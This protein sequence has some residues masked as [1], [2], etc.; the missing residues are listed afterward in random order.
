MADTIRL[1]YPERRA[2]SAEKILGWA[3]DYCADHALDPADY[4]T[5]PWAIA[6]LEDAGKITTEA[7]RIR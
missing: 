3:R 6:L 7:V 1:L 5:L 2:V 4:S